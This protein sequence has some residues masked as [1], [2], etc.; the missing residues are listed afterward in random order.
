MR[1]I[2]LAKL[3]AKFAGLPAH[4]LGRIADS[5]AKTVTTEDQIEG[6]ITELDNLP[7]PLTDYA[8]M[9]QTEGDRRVTEAQTK[10]KK[11]NPGQPLP[12]N[13]DPNKDKNKDQSTD[14]NA[15]LAEQL[16]QL[17]TQLQALQQKQVT[18]TLTGKL[19][20][21]LKD[22]KIP[23]V[24]ISKY[25]VLKEEDLDSIAAA[26]E[27]DFTAMK[28]ELANQGFAT[29]TVPQGGPI[30]GAAPTAVDADI[31]AWASKGKAA[32]TTVK[33]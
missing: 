21:R 23:E 7:I 19:K 25:S 30:I 16:K 29:T 6:K 5:L 18:E 3:R 20:E 28:Q 1:E 22:K 2:I 15:A 33:T 8:T 9:L 10:W 11:E 12:N 24:F 17:S 14:P 27:T 13:E 26:V 31:D 32:T 4:L